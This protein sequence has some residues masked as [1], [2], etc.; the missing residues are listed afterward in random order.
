MAA[1]SRSK[2]KKMAT[3]QFTIEWPVPCKVTPEGGPLTIGAEGAE[4]FVTVSYGDGP[5]ACK[6]ITVP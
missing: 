2:S 1:K 6:Y 3:D 4:I 5:D